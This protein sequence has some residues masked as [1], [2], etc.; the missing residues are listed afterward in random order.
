[1]VMTVGD[2][3]EPKLDCR[4]EYQPPE[5]PGPGQASPPPPRSSSR[6]AV[7]GLFRGQR[8]EHVTRIDLFPRPEQ[9]ASHHPLSSLPRVAVR[10]DEGLFKRFGNGTGVVAFVLDASGSMGPPR[11]EPFTERTRYA[12][13]THAMEQVLREL[14]AG[15]IVGL[16]SFGAAPADR[17]DV[18]AEETIR[19]VQ[20]LTRWDPSMTDDLMR[21]I[22]YPS[23]LPWSESPIVRTI[24]T[25]RDDLISIGA[26]GFKSIVVITDGDDNRFAED[27]IKNPEGKDVP[28]ALREA[29]RD[30]EIQLNIVGFRSTDAQEMERMNSQFQVI[31]QLPVPGR[32][33]YAED[34]VQIVSNIR[35]VLRR[36]LTYR[37]VGE[38]EQPL[39]GV[40]ARRV[41]ISRPE[42]NIRW[43]PVPLQP[44]GYKLAVQAGSRL[45][46]QTPSLALNLGDL[47]LVNMVGAEGPIRFERG[48]F[49]KEF[50]PYSPSAFDSRNRWRLTVLQ[51]QKTTTGS[52]RILV[53]LERLADARETTLRLIRPRD[54]W[55]ELAATGD[56]ANTIPTRYT[57][58]EG[59][60]APTWVIDVPDWPGDARGDTPIRPMLRAWWRE[61][62]EA[63]PARVLRGGED[64]DVDARTFSPRTI[65]VAADSVTIDGVGVEEHTV[66]VADRV[67]EKRPCLVVRLSYK[68]RPFRVRPAGVSFVG[69]EHRSY[70]AAKRYTGIFW[71]KT[72]DEVLGASRQLRLE[73]IAR[74]DFQAA[75]RQ[76]GTTI[77]LLLESPRMEETIPLPIEPVPTLL[78]P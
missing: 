69:A 76:D 32:F 27:R 66:E 73:L 74:D 26:S 30:T 21:R 42:A 1:M 65:A 62:L 22:R 78:P 12:L 75:C 28:T 37:V 13:A 41:L 64:F 57:E 7:H 48:L 17:R 50:H 15:T 5:A 51:N 20:P 46:M 6:F 34:A 68:E 59:F 54:I 53:A 9:I 44:G 58:R 60:P 25:A 43:F 11:G 52:L 2:E 45:P 47:L 40:S 23:I 71:T 4:L 36:E 31:S 61:E 77:E 29:F 70:L 14:P 18:P 10:A 16:Y 24:L 56:D 38:D 63:P 72:R 35:S 55:F 33:Y 39:P 8:F 49:A 19:T 3:G 67:W